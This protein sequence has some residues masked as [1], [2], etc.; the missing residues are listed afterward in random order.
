[1]R[2]FEANAEASGVTTAVLMENSGR[3][4]AQQT[5][6]I[7]GCLADKKIIVLIGPGNNGGDGLVAARYLQQ[8][9][10]HVTIYL[11]S[12]RKIDDDNLKLA[13]DAGVLIIDALDDR[14]QPGLATLLSACDGVLDAIFGTGQNRY[15]GGIFK[16]VLST[17]SR[18]KE[19]NPMIRVIAVD[20]PSGL[21]ADSGESDTFTPYVN[22]T[23][24]LGYP[25]RGLYAV[26]GALRAGEVIT[27]DIG[28][29]ADL[30]A[31]SS[32]ESL[33]DKWARSLLPYRFAYSH[34]GTY[35][36]VLVFAGSASYAG[37][38]YL[39]CGGV[40]RVGAGL[41]A[42]A[43][44]KALQSIVAGLLPEAVYLTLPETAGGIDSNSYKVLLEESAGHDVFLAGC[45][46]GRKESTKTVALKTI[47]HLPHSPKMVLDADA[48]NYLAASSNWW[49]RL[50]ADAVLTPHLGEMSRLCNMPVE[51][52]FANRFDIALQK[53]KEWNK[54]IVL[55]GANSIIASPNGELRINCSANA[56]LSSAGTGD[57]LAGV[58]AGLL[59]QGLSL[60]DGACLGVYL[61]AKAGGAI[62]ARLGGAGVLASDLLPELPLSIKRL[63]ETT[64][65]AE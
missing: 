51:E 12:E 34:K 23:I 29:P 30:N 26:T 63:K 59:A 35:G 65:A 64:Q 32:C 3:A 55:K 9:G 15:I 19:V 61:H 16:A 7:L 41:V 20:L 5:R 43:G 48:L 39:C 53:A 11:C 18:A 60:F 14:E 57:V 31:A 54:T 22:Y 38:A 25:K 42:L 1:M 52:I 13:L 62:C 2:Q 10:A 36:K 8:W 28:L 45:G 4:V 56:A 46:L 50:P 33:T 47:F 40:L 37:A 21:N 44:S 24:A 17:L 6:R 49:R 58:I 27:V